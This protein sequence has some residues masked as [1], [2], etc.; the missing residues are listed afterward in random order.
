MIKKEMTIKVYEVL[1]IFFNILMLIFAYQQ[2]EQKLTFAAQLNQSNIQV[3]ELILNQN[4][5]L[6]VI[7]RLTDADKIITSV[8]QAAPIVAHTDFGPTVNG[9]IAGVA[10]IGI[11]VYVVVPVFGAFATL[12]HGLIQSYTTKTIGFLDPYGYFC[13]FFET[14]N[15]DV[16]QHSSIIACSKDGDAYSFRLNS[17]NQIII[18]NLPSSRISEETRNE[19]IR[20]FVENIENSPPEAI[21]ELKNN[22]K[23][24][25][26]LYDNDCIRQLGNLNQ[27]AMSVVTNH[28]DAI[29]VVVKT[30]SELV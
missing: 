4:K 25:N 13:S 17:K 23:L 24:L 27:T 30:S 7:N 3:A 2:Y 15:P 12:S 22:M 6:A 11:M 8:K 10:T 19:N 28:S 16:F 18:E 1:Q 14:K 21:L 5:M 9:F 26:A 20:K 29:A